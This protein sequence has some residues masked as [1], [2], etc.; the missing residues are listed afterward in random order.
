MVTRKEAQSMVNEDDE[1][2]SSLMYDT[3]YIEG[4]EEFP[5]QELKEGM[6]EEMDS[7]R[8]FD[9]F[10]EVLTSELDEDTVRNAITT[11]W[12]HRW[13]GD[14]IR[15][16]LVCRGFTEEIT[17]TDQVYASTPLLVMVKLLIL[18][19]LALRW[20]ILFFDVGTAFLHAN[21][22]GDLY[23][24]PPIEFYDDTRVLWKLKK[25][26]YGLRTA[27]KAWQDHLAQLL[28]RHKFQRL[29]SE[30]NV[31]SN[32]D[33][34]IIIL[35]YVD[36]LM[37]VGNLHNIQTLVTELVKELLLK[38]TGDLTE[39]DKEVN[40]LGRLFR[41]TGDTV[42]VRCTNRYITDILEEHG[43]DKCKPA[44][45][46]GTS[47][48]SRMEHYDEP[49]DSKDHST[50]RRT[51]GKLMWL[52]GLR[53]DIF[54]AVKEL[55]RSLTGPTQHDWAKLKHLLR[56]L[57]GTH[58]LVTH[59]RPAA[60]FSLGG[61]LDLLAY[62]DSDWAGCVQTRKST[63][64]TV[65][66]VLGCT[67]TALSRT[68][69]TL[70]LSSG[71]AELYAIGTSILESLHLKHF[72]LESGLIKHCN[73]TVLTDS[74]AAKSMATRFGAT[75]R[76]RHIELRFLYLQHLIRDGIVKLQKVQ[77]TQNIAD[78]LTKYITSDVL[79]RHLNKLSLA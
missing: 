68:Q 66:Q 55:S 58:D 63:T 21:V 12:V 70:A 74:S 49:L 39:D 16:R 26:L 37:V 28:Q 51:V 23:V 73:I 33:L 56:Y 47:T 9:V 41:R 78:L 24:K 34:Q 54:Y 69:Q 6:T 1:P 15:S 76:T 71:E 38:Q 60:N 25:A 72:M 52:I 77:G 53:Y 44:T 13:K 20:S 22:T 36:D 67:L 31:Y 32:M 30:A 18:L 7:M 4:T 48:L 14:K 10:T 46:P 40:F 64:G 45:T 50:Y 27:P 35:V 43:L 5:E 79:Q 8:K 3:P 62:T 11:R 57:K 75:K 61:S 59:L 65:I 17:D 2:T 19:S 42:T 29:Q